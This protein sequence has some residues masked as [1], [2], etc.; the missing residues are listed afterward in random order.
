[1]SRSLIRWMMVSVAILALPA[2]AAAQARALQG[3][4]VADLRTMK[5]KFVGLS[6]VFP[7]DK[8]DWRPMEGVRSVKDVLILLTGEGNA[9]PTQ[10]GAPAPAGVLSDRRSESARLEALP[11]AALSAELGKAF[12]NVIAVVEGMDEGARAREI[13]FFGQSVTVAGAINMATGDMHEHLGQLIA[14]ARMN[15]IVPPWSR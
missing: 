9:F 15:R 3:V 1:M 11:K 2:A 6:G 8:Y 12:D 7:E 10:W 4:Q 5:D 14:Y 13:T